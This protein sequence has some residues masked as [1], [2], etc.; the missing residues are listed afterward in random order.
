MRGT[1]WLLLVAIAAILGGVAVTYRIQKKALKQQAPQKPQAL[2][3]ELSS[4]GAHYTHRQLDKGRTVFLIEADDFRQA[5]DSSRIDLKGVTLEVYNK[6]AT[7]YDLIKS[8]TATYFTSENRLFSEG[9]VDI[10]IGVP[11]EGEQPPNLVSIH[12][13][14]VTLDAASGKAETDSPATFDFRNGSGKAIGAAYDPGAR[15]LLMKKDAEVNWNSA[16]PNGKALK[17]EAASL[18]Y[19]EGSSDIWLR[20]WGRLTRDK[21][22][23]QGE[24]AVVHLRQVE[25]GGETKTIIRQIQAKNARGTDDYPSRKLQYS[26]GYLAVDFDDSGVAQIARGQ[27]NARLNSTSATA[28]TNVKSDSVEMNFET[29]DGGSVLQRVL[30]TGNA[31]VTSRPLPAPGR[32]LPETHVLSSQSL[33]MKMRDGGKEIDSVVT[34]APGALEFLPNTPAQRHRTLNGNDMAIAYGR[35]N[36][37]DSFRATGVKTQTDPNEEERKRDRQRAFTSSRELLAR[38]DPKTNRMD[39]MEQTG[40]FAYDEGDRHARAAKAT[41]DSAQD[42]I[43]LQSAARVWEP[44][45]STS[46]D[47]IRMNQTTGDFTGE[48]NVHSSQV[49]DKDQKKSGDMLSGDD[50]I[51][52]QARKMTSANRNRLIHYEGGA[53]MTQGANRIQAEA[54]DLDREKKTLAANGSVMTDLWEKPKDDAAKPGQKTAPPASPVRTIVHAPKLVYTDADRLA[55]YSGGANLLRGPLKV[56]SKELRAYLNS[57]GDSSLDKAFADGAVEIVQT[58]PGRTR[59]GTGEHAEYYAADQKVVL[60]GARARMADS[61]SGVSEG[62]ELT[63]YANDDRLLGSGATDDPVKTR[64]NRGRK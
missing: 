56:N 31:S 57:G 59:T 61:V 17:I 16:A 47:V 21:S 29:G 10:T 7:S 64:I 20:P 18:T 46:A 25:A 42:L 53:V 44:A 62:R 2:P 45:S 36:R 27:G 38:F 12:T 15:E 30:A 13:S 52:A 55:F 4:A 3:R 8:A 33:E 39:Y 22:V 34:H 1:R 23:V 32:A 5:S 19:V 51:V 9:A 26:A 50:P 48:G 28:E 60:R 49:P 14:G 43:V 63:Y 6:T 11:A 58:V 41:L 40:D 54:I 24:D 37:I 35:E